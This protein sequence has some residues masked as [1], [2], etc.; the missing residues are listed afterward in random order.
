MRSKASGKNKRN[1][2]SPN[3]RRSNSAKISKHPS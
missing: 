3:A 1:S 2:E